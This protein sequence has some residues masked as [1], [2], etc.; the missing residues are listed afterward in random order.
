MQKNKKKGFVL[1]AVVI[2]IATILTV[3]SVSRVVTINFLVDTL[4]LKQKRT[5]LVTQVSICVQ[6][7]LKNLNNGQIITSTALPMYIYSPEGNC[8]IE[9]YSISAGVITY[10]IHS[11]IVGSQLYMRTFFNPISQNSTVYNINSVEFF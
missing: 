3:I 10:S 11:K 2:S 4:L 7:A 9:E 6:Y 1:T 5:T 8:S